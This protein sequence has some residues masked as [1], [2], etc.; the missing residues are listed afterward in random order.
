MWSTCLLVEIHNT[1]GVKLSILFSFLLYAWFALDLNIFS[2]LTKALVEKLV[3]DMKPKKYLKVSIDTNPSSQI[4][5]LMNF[6]LQL[7][8]LFKRRETN[9]TETNKKFI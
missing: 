8:L 5:I 2:I 9:Q 1:C 6:Q 7:I 3:L 4:S